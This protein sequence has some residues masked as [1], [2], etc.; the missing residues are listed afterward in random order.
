M[1]EDESTVSL[2]EKDVREAISLLTACYYFNHVLDLAFAY[3]N[4]HEGEAPA[5]AL[6]D[7]LLESQ[8]TLSSYL[9]GDNT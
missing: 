2:P 1:A 3:R 9:E 6:S 4:L 7:A 5:S 8:K